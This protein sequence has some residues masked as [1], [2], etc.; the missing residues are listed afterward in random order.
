MN[1]IPTTAEE[2]PTK[3]L[4]QVA[5]I[6]VTAIVIA[7]VAFDG[8]YTLVNA[9]TWGVLTALAIVFATETRK[10]MPV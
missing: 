10:R 9:T 7:P 6:I 4:S 5:A 1:A 2:L 3:Q 8:G